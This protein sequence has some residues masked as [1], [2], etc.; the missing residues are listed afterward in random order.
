MATKRIIQLPT[1]NQNNQITW[2]NSSQGGYLRK[3]PNELPWWDWPNPKNVIQTPQT[4]ANG[5]IT[6][7]WWKKTAMNSPEEPEVWTYRGNNGVVQ[8]INKNTTPTNWWFTQYSS[9][10]DRS[11][12]LLNTGKNWTTNW[13]PQAA[14]AN[15]P[16]V[17][18]YAGIDK[19]YWNNQA[20]IDLVNKQN[21]LDTLSEAEKA[22]RLAGAYN[23][24]PTVATAQNPVIK[25]TLDKP[26]EQTVTP[27]TIQW[28]D[29][30]TLNSTLDELNYKVN[31][32]GKQLSKD[33]YLAYASAKRQLQDMMKPQALTGW[34]DSLITN[35]ENEIK[36]VTDESKINNDQELADFTR[37]QEVYKQAEIDAINQADEEQKKTLWFILGWQGAWQGTFAVEQIGKITQNSL[38]KKQALNEAVQAK[39]DLYWSQLRKDSQQTIQAMKD[40]LDSYYMKAAEFDVDNIKQMNEYNAKEWAS[41]IEQI[42]KMMALAQSQAMAMQPLTEQEKAQAQAFAG[43]LYD[44]EWNFQNNVFE[45]L[46]K[47]NPKLANA[48]VLQGTAI[49]K[50]R[51]SNDMA[52]KWLDADIKRA[53][54]N[55]LLNPAKEYDYKQ[56][57]DWNRIA[58]DKNNPLNQ[59]NITWW[60][61]TWWLW[62]MRYLA[63]QFP[64]QARAKNNNPAGI[65]W[66]ANFDNPKPWTTAYALQ[67][68]G[69]NFEK[70]TPRPWNE[71]GNYVTF[72]TMEDWLAAQRIM[73]TQTYGNTTVGN[74]LAKWVWT[75]EWPRYAQQVAGM[76]GV[77]V[78]ATV[79]Q[80]SDQQL[81]TL[82]MAKIQKESPWLSKILQQQTQQKNQEPKQSDF[83]QYTSYIENG[84]LPAWIK[85]WTNKAE[86]F[87]QQAL[88]WYIQGKEQEFNWAWLTISNPTAFASAVTDAAKI[89]EVNKAVLTLPKFKDTMDQLISLE[90]EYWTEN[91]PTQAKQTMNMLVKDAQLQ[92]KE[93]YN[94][95]VL[96]WPDLSL[97]ESII[98]NPTS[99]SALW[100]QILWWVSYNEMLKSAKDKVLWNAYA[101]ARTIWLSPTWQ[102]TW[103]LSWWRRQG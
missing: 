19:N 92:A 39:I 18:K 3:L 76:A 27:A 52:M 91:R 2:G 10:T 63:N 56:D 38:A 80:L 84:K 70:G 96:N 13:L 51:I 23:P 36:Q 72:P 43:N 82:Q 79:N 45:M 28:A 73:M 90:K 29:I 32:E 1:L 55:K 5:N 61:M 53:Q 16:W 40:R 86:V 26:Q 88:D 54:L 97:M 99:W 7:W 89:K 34:L 77:D 74:M 83:P 9:K 49:Q 78:N 24:T 41:K 81:Q 37:S 69:V 65:T 44:N 20:G 11:A 101:Q 8:T 31:V 85:D 94:L 102:A 17:T 47:V 71:G 48:A 33:E 68:A 62:D 12:A 14:P 67:Q 15:L 75:W 42:D 100:P 4:D 46:Y 35:K 59:I 58:I 57:A 21:E 95:W 93:I 30:N 50:E 25:K 6:G 66:N 60:G 22:Q 103:T 87:K 98:P 64:W